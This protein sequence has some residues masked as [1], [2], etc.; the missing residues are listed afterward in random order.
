MYEYLY[1]LPGNTVVLI[2]CTVVLIGCTVVL[3]GNTVVLIGCTFSPPPLSSGP[4]AAQARLVPRLFP[5]GDYLHINLFIYSFFYVHF[6]TVFPSLYPL[7]DLSRAS[8][9]VGIIHI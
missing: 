5:G 7:P 1:Q 9:Q 6:V 2:G 4:P 8:S 3:I